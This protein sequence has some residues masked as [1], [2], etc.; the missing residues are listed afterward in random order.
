MKSWLRVRRTIRPKAKEAV[1]LFKKISGLDERL[2]LQ[3]TEGAVGAS[4][5]HQALEVLSKDLEKALNEKNKLVE[6]SLK[7]LL[8]Q[9]N[10]NIESLRLELEDE[11]DA[12]IKDLV[13]G[14]E[15]IAKA[16]YEKAGISEE[17]DKLRIIKDLQRSL[18]VEYLNEAKAWGW[19][20]E[21]TLLW[22][23]L[24]GRI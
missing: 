19:E 24:N 11:E 17:S 5:V 6:A 23:A 14:A 20:N 1:E 15:N 8:E 2:K 9:A 13:T 10:K 12:R 18:G 3:G 16:I 22:L 4:E 7:K 21:V